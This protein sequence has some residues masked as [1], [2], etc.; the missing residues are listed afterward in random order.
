MASPEEWEPVPGG[1]TVAPRLETVISIRLDAESVRLIRQAARAQGLT[2]SVFVRR[3]ARQAA[4][5][6]LRQAPLIVQVIVEADRT[7]AP[8]L[9]WDAN[10]R[11]IAQTPAVTE[12]SLQTT[13][14][15]TAAG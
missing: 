14:L 11:T 2:Q 6:L 5:S 7:L 3:A 10:R 13:P 4:E 15:P 8:P 12:V 9:F 1:V